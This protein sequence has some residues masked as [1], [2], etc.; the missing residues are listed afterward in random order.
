MLFTEEMIHWTLTFSLAVEAAWQMVM[1][2]GLNSVKCSIVFDKWLQQRV[3]A[4]LGFVYER[5]DAQLSLEVLCDH[6]QEA[7][8]L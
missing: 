4:L 6:A 1:K 8:V 5:L 2:E 3:R 7:E